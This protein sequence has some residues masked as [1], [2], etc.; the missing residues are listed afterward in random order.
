MNQF[1]TAILIGLAAAILVGAA[2]RRKLWDLDLSRFVNQQKDLATL[3]WGIRFSPD[4]SKVAVGFGP[5]W[6]F[7]PRPRHIVIAATDQP[8]IA[9]R[10]FDL[11]INVVLP[12]ADVI[13]W[14]PSGEALVV[15]SRPT[16]IILRLAQEAPCIFPEETEFG[17]FLSG[18]RMVFFRRGSLGWPQIRVLRPDCSLADSWEMTNGPADVLDTSPDR[19]LIAVNQRLGTD[20]SSVMVLVAAG[21]HE[22]KQSWMWDAADTTSS[23][24]SGFRFADQGRLFCG[25]YRGRNPGADV[26]VACWDTQ[27]GAMISHNDKVGVYLGSVESAGGV[28]LAITD[29]R[30]VVREGKFW[31]FLD[32]DG[33][34]YT[35]RRR[36]IWDARS[37]RELASW[38]GF[39]TGAL[40]QEQLWG[41]DLQHA[42]TIKSNPVLSLSPTG[43]YIAEGGS[44]SV[45]AYAVQ[46]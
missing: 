45:S 31:Q 24:A 10:E 32:M 39:A 1:R 33:V 20:G 27:S 19:D 17:G 28:M 23:F 8:S 37:G 35:P 42:R 12:S 34:G 25:G 4:E 22:I 43:K 18:D 40:H 16:P 2:G 41:K 11:N 5:R 9:L 7:D 15:R 13:A 14:S 38:G 3:V 30:T 36:I 29:Y 46:P 26:N 21:T 44:G 6:D